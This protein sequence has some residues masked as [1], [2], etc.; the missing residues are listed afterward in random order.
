[1]IRVRVA[2]AFVLALVAAPAVAADYPAPK[3]G[4]WIARDFTDELLHCVCW[5]FKA[6][7]QSLSSFL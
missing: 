7:L 1:M 3:Q 6:T 5:R 2:V 4:D